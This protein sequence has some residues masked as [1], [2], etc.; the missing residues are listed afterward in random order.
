VRRPI[1]AGLLL[2]VIGTAV[3]IGEWRGLLAILIWSVGHTLKAKREEAVM[4]ATF[5]DQYQRQR[6]E[7]RFLLPRL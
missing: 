2:A 5:G 7:T 6:T 4:I 3:V 1:Y